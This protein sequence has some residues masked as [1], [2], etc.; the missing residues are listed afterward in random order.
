M[1]DEIITLRTEMSDSLLVV[2]TLCDYSTCPTIKSNNETYALIVVKSDGESQSIDTFSGHG[3]ESRQN[4]ALGG[5][6]R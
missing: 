6:Y 5:A 2:I 4:L 3:F 1:S